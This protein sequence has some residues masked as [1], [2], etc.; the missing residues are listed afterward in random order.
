MQFSDLKTIDS[1]LAVIYGDPTKFLMSGISHSDAPLPNTFIFVKSRKFLSEIGRRSI[2]SVFP[3]SGLVIEKKIANLL[4]DDEFKNIQNSFG[5][6]ASIDSVAS[7][8]CSLSKPFY[9]LRFK[10]LN[11]QVDGRQLSEV[12]IDPSAQIAQTAFIGSHVKI[13]KNVKIMPGVVILPHASIGDD[14]I[15]FPNVTIYPFCRIGNNCRIHSGTNIGTDGFGYNFIEG[16][17][18][19]IWHLCSVVIEDDVEIGSSTNI[20]CG[21]FIDTY[22]G[23]GTKIDNCVQISHNVQVGKHVVLCGNSGLAGSV[24]VDDFCVFGG[25]AGVAPGAR[26][27][28]GVQVAP[29]SIISE[30]SIVAPFTKWGGHPARPMNEWLKSKAAV[31]KLLKK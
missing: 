15:I 24:E 13:G 11:Y 9:D 10:D 4:K 17:H 27:G 29:L 6:I 8:M 28:K 16:E 31:R 19:K 26:L 22:I 23:Q 20:D 1:S 21:A 3:E 14:T 7:G 12:E 25:H 2:D 18:K 30:N 5:W